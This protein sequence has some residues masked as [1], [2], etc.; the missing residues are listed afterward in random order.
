MSFSEYFH[1][2]F[3]QVIFGVFKIGRFVCN[4]VTLCSSEF[5]WVIC[6]VFEKM[7]NCYWKKKH[8][9]I[10]VISSQNMR[11]SDMIEIKRAITFISIFNQFSVFPWNIFYFNIYSS[12]TWI[13]FKTYHPFQVTLFFFHTALVGVHSLTISESLFWRRY[14]I[15]KVVRRIILNLELLTWNC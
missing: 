9:K 13:L 6:K 12:K 15:D 7:N 11:R 4:K 8:N 14:F 3:S 2:S 1:C 5:T 10:L